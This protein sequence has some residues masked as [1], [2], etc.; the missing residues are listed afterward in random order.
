M[1]KNELSA[2]ARLLK[3]PAVEHLRE[4]EELQ[5]AITA[6]MNREFFT[7]D[8]ALAA[9]GGPG[10]IDMIKINHGN[11]SKYVSTIL[12]AYDPDQFVNTV[13]WVY[14]TYRA[15]GVLPVYWTLQIPQWIDILTDMLSDDAADGILPFYRFLEEHHS[16]FTELTNEDG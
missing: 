6:R 7:I 9:T 10:N 12:A 15:H 2:Q 3:M 13:L 5:P 4:Y 8:D 11:H 14:K 1:T 16:S